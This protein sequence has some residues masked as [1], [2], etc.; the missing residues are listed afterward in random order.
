MVLA[1]SKFALAL[2]LICLLT[3]L[4]MADNA[5]LT[6]CQGECITS[7]VAKADSLGCNAADLLCLCKSS[8]FLSGV[9]D[10]ASQSCPAGTDNSSLNAYEAKVCGDAESTS[11]VSA[12]AS[13]VFTVTLMPTFSTSTTA[14][15]TVESTT[16]GASTAAAASQTS[17][18][19]TSTSH[20]GGLST[21]AKAGIGV[22]SAL[23]GLLI[24]ALA[25]LC[26]R[27]LD[28]S[29]NEIGPTKYIPKPRADTEAGFVYTNDFDLPNGGIVAVVEIGNPHTANCL[30]SP[31]LRRIAKVFADLGRRESLRAV[32]PVFSAGAD[33]KEM[34]ALSSAQEAQA[35]ISSIFLACESIRKCPV[36]VIARIDG[37][38]FGAAIELAA[39]CDFRYGTARSRFSMKEVALGIPSVVHARLL[40]NIMGW[41]ETKRMVLLAQDYTAQYMSKAGFLDGCYRTP[42]YLDHQIDRVVNMIAMNAPRA[43]R[44]QKSLNRFWEENSLRDGLVHGIDT[45]AQIWD[46]GGKEP[47]EYMRA[48]LN[49]TKAAEELSDQDT[50]ISEQELEKPTSWNFLKLRTYLEDTR[51]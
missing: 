48:W 19:A 22:G 47:K 44:A 51:G 36:P 3:S 1:I 4:V 2:R 6:D 43:M 24:L 16:G 31:T 9:Y 21:G 41:Q 39:C 28:K 17:S 12:T 32:N 8:S 18:V 27:Q 13:A 49:R 20:G 26:L 15:S 5:T 37:A 11:I 10:C 42:A 30:S 35:F 7:M 33:I 34:E 23:G 29:A 25:F 50:E 46:D 14:A 40:A 45:F 38:C